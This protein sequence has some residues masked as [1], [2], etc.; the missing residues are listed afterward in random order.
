MLFGQKRVYSRRFTGFCFGGVIFELFVPNRS[1]E[2]G[3]VELQG[4]C[5]DLQGQF[6]R[7]GLAL[8]RVEIGMT[9]GE[10][11]TVCW[12]ACVLFEWRHGYRSG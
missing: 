4:L 7:P 3:L 12:P 10:F 5:F 11:G 6:G 2:F 1:A 8:L 9:G